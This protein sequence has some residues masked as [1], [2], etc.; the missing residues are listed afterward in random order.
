MSELSKK[1]EKGDYAF[2]VP[3]DS[4]IRLHSTNNP[5]SIGTYSSHGCI[6]LSPPVAEEL[7]PTL[8]K[9][10]PHKEPKKNERG[11][12]YPLDRIIPVTIR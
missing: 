5:K 11:I 4:G 12:I 6:R 2:S 8:L 1:N 10:I 7:F 3:G 9:Y